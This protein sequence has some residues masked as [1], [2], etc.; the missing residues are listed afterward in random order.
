[1]PQNEKPGQSVDWGLAT[2]NGSR[3]EALRRWAQ[4]PLERV[5]AALEEMQELSDMLAKTPAGGEAASSPAA[6]SAVHE[7]PGD[8]PAKAETQ[9]RSSRDATPTGN[10]RSRQPNKKGGH[11]K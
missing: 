7:H 3:R 1:M 6:E 11:E 5:I 9:P 8:Y 10:R 2:W 4:L